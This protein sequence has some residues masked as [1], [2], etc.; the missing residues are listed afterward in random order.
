MK[1]TVTVTHLDM[2]LPDTRRIIADLASSIISANWWQGRSFEPYMPND[3]DTTF[4][5]LDYGN[6]WKLKFTD[7]HHTFEVLHCYQINDQTRKLEYSDVNEKVKDLANELAGRMVGT[8][9]IDMTK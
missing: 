2:C 6:D 9:A 5:T 8:T 3:G 7:D 1:V 4:W